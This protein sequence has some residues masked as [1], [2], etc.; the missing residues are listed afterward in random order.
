MVKLTACLLLLA[1]AV[2]AKLPVT[3]ISELRAQARRNSALAAR[4]ENL[5]AQYPAH[6]IKIPID[7][8][9][10]S[11][12]YE[13]HSKDKFNL[14]YWFDASHYKEGGPVIILHGGETSGE[15][16]LPFLYKGILAQL[17]Q[18]T[19]GIGVVME[20]RYYGTSLPTRD[21]SNKSL[22]FLTTEQALADTAYFSKNI[23]FPGLER[24]N[25]TAPGTAH[26]VYGG[27]YA[28]GQV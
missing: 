11:D 17:A 3:P 27:S 2:Q 24:Y 19:N 21:F 6:Q 8:F 5:N 28:G 7:H 9:P 22:R 10:E 18:A 14:R 1:A 16:R 12:R 4:S 20:H 15:G 23:K 26:I 25:L 13:P